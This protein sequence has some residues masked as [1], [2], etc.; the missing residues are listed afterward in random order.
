[1]LLYICSEYCPSSP[2][3]CAPSSPTPLHVCPQYYLYICA[4]RLDASE[5]LSIA[6]QSVYML[7]KLHAT[8]TFSPRRGGVCIKSVLTNETGEEALRY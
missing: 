8:N 5:I 6:G 4:L 2:S 1:M 7:L 3:Y